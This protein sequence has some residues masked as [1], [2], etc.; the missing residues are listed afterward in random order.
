V[1]IGFHFGK[2]TV[3]YLGLQKPYLQTAQSSSIFLL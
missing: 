1:L 3:Q 2:N